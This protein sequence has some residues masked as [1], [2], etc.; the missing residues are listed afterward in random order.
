LTLLRFDDTWKKYSESFLLHWTSK[1]PLLE[2]LEDKAVDNA[3]KRLWL[4]AALS[5]KFHM[6]TCLTQAKVTEITLL[7][8]SSIS[9]KRMPWESL[10]NLILAHAKLY[11]HSHAS[12]TKIKRDDNI[13]EQ[14]GRVGGR[15]R[16]YG[17]RGGGRGHPIPGRGSDTYSRHP[18][19]D[20]V[21]TTVIGPNMAM[22]SNMIFKPEEWSKLTPAQKSQLRA[23]KKLTPKPTPPHISTLPALQIHATDLQTNNVASSPRSSTSRLSPTSGVIQS[24]RLHVQRC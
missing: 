19:A 8:M 4:T 12:T 10:Y 11:D 3:T 1:I 22:K 6:A 2:Q 20:L 16:G 15:V 14:G 7:G 5:T 18:R 24:R 21:Y 13:H 9:S 17:G 23:A